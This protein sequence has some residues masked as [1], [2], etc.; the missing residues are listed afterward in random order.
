MLLPD[1]YKDL[2]AVRT[3]ITSAPMMAFRG[4]L[5]PCISLS[6]M[7]SLSSFSLAANKKPGLLSKSVTFVLLLE[8]SEECFWIAPCLR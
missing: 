1:A 6:F 3:D 2:S 4:E 5:S 7:T 8:A